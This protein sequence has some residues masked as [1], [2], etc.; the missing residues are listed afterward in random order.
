MK[1]TTKQIL[2]AYEKATQELA[3]MFVKK[4]FS[5]YFDGSDWD[6]IVEELDFGFF[7]IADSYHVGADFMRMALKEK[8]S[9][10]QVH[11]YLDYELEMA[12]RGK[13]VKVNF[14]SYL[15]GHPLGKV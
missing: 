15:M 12:Q 9:I 7:I 6:D 11:E 14:N 2:K 8:A 10:K 13:K 3:E 1:K 4:Y 5:N